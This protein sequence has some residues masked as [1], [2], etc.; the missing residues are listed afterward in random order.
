MGP[1]TAQLVNANKQGDGVVRETRDIQDTEVFFLSLIEMMTMMM[2][3][4]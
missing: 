2:R 1:I 4:K 3:L